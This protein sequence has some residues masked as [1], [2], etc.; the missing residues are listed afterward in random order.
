M[1][2]FDF[3]KKFQEKKEQEKRV[4][5]ALQDLKKIENTSDYREGI[6]KSFY[7]LETLGAEY[8]GIKRGEATTVREYVRLLEEDGIIRKDELKEYVT[9]FEVSKYSVYDPTLENF[10]KSVTVVRDLEKR[11]KNPKNRKVAASKG[12]KGKRGKKR[13][14][15][16][17]RTAGGDGEA[18][19]RKRKVKRRTAD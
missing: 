12:K 1:G 11:F 17:T 13:R 15:A 14:R 6:I 8:L 2:I 10:N 4:Q 9:A 3:I 18:P 5:A 7:I 19:R 16:P